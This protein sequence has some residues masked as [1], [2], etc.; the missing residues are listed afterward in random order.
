MA[1]DLNEHLAILLKAVLCLNWV[2]RIKK[3]KQI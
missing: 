2:T 1:L 3:I